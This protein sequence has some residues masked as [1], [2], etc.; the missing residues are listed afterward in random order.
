MSQMQG[1]N[2]KYWKQFEQIAQMYE[3]RSSHWDV[4]KEEKK[5]TYR[6][7]QLQENE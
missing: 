4:Q 6:A 2:Q 7:V 5:K 3:Q 1:K